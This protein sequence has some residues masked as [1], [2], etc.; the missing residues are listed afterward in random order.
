MAL[1][2]G[3]I[4]CFIGT[5]ATCLSLAEYASMFVHRSPVPRTPADASHQVPNVGGTVSMGSRTGA[6][7]LLSN[8]ELDIRLDHVL[9]LAIDDRV[10][11]VFGC[12]DH[13]GLSI[14]QPS[15]IRTEAVARNAHLLGHYIGGI[16][17]QCLWGQ[18]SF[19]ARRLSVSRTSR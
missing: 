5:L 12:D 6:Q 15:D 7:G 19:Y 18:I 4:F 2:Y 16:F 14:G 13:S 10:T 8:N 17:R 1:I 3:F 9:G 11:C